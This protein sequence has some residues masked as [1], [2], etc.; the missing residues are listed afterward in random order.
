MVVQGP[1]VAHCG[2]VGGLISMNFDAVETSSSIA[3]S[4][5]ESPLFIS[6]TTSDDSADSSANMSYDG[7][8]HVPSPLSTGYWTQPSSRLRGGFRYLTIVLTSDNPV[9]I[10]NVTCAINFMPNVQDL[11]NYSGYFYAPDP[12]Y[13]DRDF[14][15]KVCFISF[16]D[17]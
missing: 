3:L 12:V 1:C 2:Q 10:S 15:T 13:S 16:D 5:T 4:F 6:P 14:L 7:V 8:L 17:P 11:R 9:T